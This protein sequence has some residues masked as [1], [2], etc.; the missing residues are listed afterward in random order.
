MH[1]LYLAGPVCMLACWKRGD[2]AHAL[3]RRSWAARAGQTSQRELSTATACH[4]RKVEEL[5]ALPLCMA[6][7]RA[8]TL[9]QSL[10]LQQTLVRQAALSFRPVHRHPSRRDSR[11]APPLPGSAGRHAAAISDLK[12]ETHGCQGLH[13]LVQDVHAPPG[14]GSGP[15]RGRPALLCWLPPGSF[16]RL[17]PRLPV[18]LSCLQPA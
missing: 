3:H 8:T 16:Q 9:P 12:P 13:M 5:R 10:V 14:R 2:C 17:P 18:S 15:W 11:A 6:R 7:V 4:G 1:L